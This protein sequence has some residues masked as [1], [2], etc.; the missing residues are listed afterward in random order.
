MSVKIAHF[1]GD[2][3]YLP[4][5]VLR[6]TGIF[7]HYS[8]V[9]DFV[10]IVFLIFWLFFL[11][12]TC[13]VIFWG[14]SF[15]AKFIGNFFGVDEKLYQAIWKCFRRSFFAQLP[16]LI[17]SV[18]TL[19]IT[20]LSSP[21]YDTPSMS[22]I[23]GYLPFGKFLGAMDEGTMA[24]CGVTLFVVLTLVTAS[25]VMKILPDTAWAFL[26][27]IFVG[28]IVGVLVLNFLMPIAAQGL[29]SIRISTESS[30]VTHF[31]LFAIYSL[32]SSVLVLPLTG[33]KEK[34]SKLPS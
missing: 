12:V 33:K 30:I 29:K 32:V 22:E 31:I 27:G 2:P 23:A 25:Y 3:T 28:V 16:I 10:E 24:M 5:S 6:I 1:L 26:V 7:F 34:T 8:E 4:P 18:L 13:F 9:A 15:A 19:S 11:V 20:P 17:L 21:N 14:I